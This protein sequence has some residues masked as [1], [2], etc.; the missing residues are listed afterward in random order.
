MPPLGFQLLMA[1][2]KPCSLRG[3]ILLPNPNTLGGRQP[4][5]VAFLHAEGVVEFGQIAKYAGGSPFFMRQALTTPQGVVIVMRVSGSQTASGVKLKT[6]PTAYLR[7]RQHLTANH[8][9]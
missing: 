7:S 6:I 5:L 1:S 9:P 4:Q 2:F 3:Q 8:A